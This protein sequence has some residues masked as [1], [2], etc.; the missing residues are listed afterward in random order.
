MTT[1]STPPRT[2]RELSKER[3]LRV[4]EATAEVVRERGLAATRISDIGARAEMSPGHVMY[5]FASK[6]HLLME[7]VRSSEDRFYEEV[8]AEVEAQPTARHKIVRLIELWCP[9]GD[10]REAAAAW[11]LWP[12][13]WARSMRNPG[14]AALRESLDRRWT[15]FVVA[16]TESGVRRGEFP[17]AGAGGFAQLLTAL[18]DGLAL[19]VMSG[20]PD[21]THEDMRRTLLTFAAWQLGFTDPGDRRRPEGVRPKKGP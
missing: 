1:T 5:Y 18:L 19:R 11:V 6:D 7:A 9:S 3:R 15:E 4:L 2:M 14:L 13:L 20:D 10:T 16:T 17:R 12:E 21:M 8:I